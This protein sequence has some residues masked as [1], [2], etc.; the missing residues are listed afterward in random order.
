MNDTIPVVHGELLQWRLSANRDIFESK[1]V[2]FCF[3]NK[4]YFMFE[5]R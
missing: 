3:L 2:Q 1:N 4:D 5:Y